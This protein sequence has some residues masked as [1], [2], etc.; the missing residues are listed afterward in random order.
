MTLFI[1]RFALLW[2]LASVWAGLALG[3]LIKTSDTSHQERILESLFTRCALE[4]AGTGGAALAL[5]FGPAF[6]R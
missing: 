3:Q 4:Y 1:F 2:G 6:S 5:R